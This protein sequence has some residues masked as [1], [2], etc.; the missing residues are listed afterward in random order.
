MKTA[1]G[2]RRWRWVVAAAA[3]AALVGTAAWTGAR[4][5]EEYPPPENHVDGRMTGGGNFTCYDAEGN[6]VKTTHGF[7]L[8]CS[9]AN[10]PNRFE[11]N[12]DGNQFHLEDYQTAFCLDDPTIAPQPPAAP[13]DT[14]VFTGL[15][16]LNGVS[17]ASISATLTDAGEP[18]TDD[19]VLLTISAGGS[20]VLTCDANLDGGN[21]QAH[22]LTGR[23][24]R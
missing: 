15:G 10:T 7:E 18:G 22:R 3:V 13:L 23:D 20:V 1:T 12:W 14:L 8:H 21:Q 5:G 6:E 16:R 4:A 11:L 9:T 24:A 2:R 17:G 19:H